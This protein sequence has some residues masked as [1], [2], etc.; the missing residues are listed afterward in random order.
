MPKNFSYWLERARVSQ[1]PPRPQQC[2]QVTG[3]VP[4]RKRLREAL[5]RMKANIVTAWQWNDFLRSVRSR[6]PEISGSAMASRWRGSRCV[7]IVDPPRYVRYKKRAKIFHPPARTVLPGTAH[8]IRV[9]VRGKRGRD[10]ESRKRR[11]T[12]RSFVAEYGLETMQRSYRFGWDLKPSGKFTEGASHATL[13]NVLGSLKVNRQ[14][15]RFESAEASKVSFR[16]FVVRQKRDAALAKQVVK[17]EAMKKAK[18]FQAEEQAQRENEVQRVL[19]AFEEPSWRRLGSDIFRFLY[20]N[21][22]NRKVKYLLR[23]YR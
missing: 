12:L 2:G 17:A 5:N 19:A 14:P 7:R 23:G 15:T 3:K 22:G 11:I 20:P 1:V 16:D 9:R 6:F 13:G 8:S 21:T 10:K 4:G 18:A